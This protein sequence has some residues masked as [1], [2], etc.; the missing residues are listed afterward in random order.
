MADTFILTNREAGLVMI[1]N[2][3]EISAGP[4]E[5]S[6]PKL[7]GPAHTADNYLSLMNGDHGDGW[8]VERVVLVEHSFLKRVAARMKSITFLCRDAA[9]KKVAPNKLMMSD[10][11]FNE[12]LDGVDGHVETL[13]KMVR[14]EQK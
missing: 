1:Q 12:T 6:V 10:K 11:A 5:T 4:I 14:P 3:Q 13:I 2:M 8:K 7:V 9:D